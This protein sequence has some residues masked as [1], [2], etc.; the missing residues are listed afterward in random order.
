MT[1]DKAIEEIRAIRQQISEAYGH[2]VKAFLEH[3]RELERQ[4]QERLIGRKDAEATLPK[5]SAVGEQGAGA[6]HL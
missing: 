6:E 2:N 1:P 3:Y 5:A 4:Y